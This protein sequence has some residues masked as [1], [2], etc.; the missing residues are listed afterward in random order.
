MPEEPKKEQQSLNTPINE[1]EI[2]ENKTEQ[3]PTEKVCDSVGIGTGKSTQQ[4]KT[5]LQPQITENPP[6]ELQTSSEGKEFFKP[7]QNDLKPISNKFETA[8]DQTNTLKH[9]ISGL[10]QILGWLESLSLK[11]GNKPHY[12]DIDKVV[13][14]ISSTNERLGLCTSVFQEHEKLKEKVEP[15]E[16][17]DEKLEK[18]VI[19]FQEANNQQLSKERDNYVR[20]IQTNTPQQHLRQLEDKIRQSEE[21]YNVLKNERDELVREKNKI[22]GELAAH[23]RDK[24]TTYTTHISGDTKP[25]HHILYQEFK[26]LKS[27][28]FNAVSDKIFH[29]LCEQ[30]SDLKSNRKQEIARIKSVFS[31]KIIINGMKMF[32]GNSSFSPEILENALKV[33]RQSF[34]RALEIEENSQIPETLSNKLENLIKQGLKLFDKTSSADTTA[35][36]QN[37]EEFTKAIKDISRSIYTALQMPEETNISEE[38]RANT[39]SLVRKGLEL[40]KKIASADPPGNLWIEQKGNVFKSEKHEATLGCE[41]AGPILWTVYPGYLVGNRIFEK[42]LVFTRQEN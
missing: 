22:L 11:I 23:N 34:Y 31:E 17:N 36:L 20:P 10:K 27:Q 16:K 42:A 28:E 32:T 41:E 35:R 4:E 26:Q 21:K 14:F 38:I 29:Y 2:T 12:Q 37:E 9:I 25:Q 8:I 5:A 13:G 6:S 18:P 7:S 39:D 33:I 24:T 1:G 15:L 40:V 19:K 30:N 3:V